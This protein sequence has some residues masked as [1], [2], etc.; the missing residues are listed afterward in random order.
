MYL[1]PAGRRSDLLP[2]GGSSRG[3]KK[4]PSAEENTSVSFRKVTTLHKG[5]SSSLPKRLMRAHSH[6]SAL[7]SGSLS[8]L[9]KVVL[10][11]IRP[12]AKADI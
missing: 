6:R 3:S 10:V 7:R 2:A 9:Q 12:V 11:H 5:K 8:L 1:Q 4:Q